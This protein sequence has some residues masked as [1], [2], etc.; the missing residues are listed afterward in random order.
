M[1]V[2]KWN[3]EN[4][5]DINVFISWMRSDEPYDRHKAMTVLRNGTIDREGHERH[6]EVMLKIDR[7]ILARH[8]HEVFK[9]VQVPEGIVKKDKYS[10]AF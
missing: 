6:Q 7:M 10:W 9:E 2:P 3:Y 4:P 1:L 8:K 5:D